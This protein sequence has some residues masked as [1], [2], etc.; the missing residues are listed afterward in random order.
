MA[1]LDGSVT[2]ASTVRD[3]RAEHGS[4]GR[5]A[6]DHVG[7]RRARRGS[8]AALRHG[9]GRLC[10]VRHPHPGGPHRASQRPPGDRGGPLAGAPHP[11]AQRVHGITQL[12]SPPGVPSPLTTKRVA[13]ALRATATRPAPTPAKASRRRARRQPQRGQ[14]GR[15]QRAH[16]HLRGRVQ[17]PGHHRRARC[18]VASA[19]STSSTRRASTVSRASTTRRPS[20]ATSS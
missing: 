16:R 18:A 8:G 2:E 15:L 20:H 5:S 17:L 7:R 9:G 12:T 13:A 3:L 14:V 6:R 1:E 10:R 4:Q 19:T 11:R